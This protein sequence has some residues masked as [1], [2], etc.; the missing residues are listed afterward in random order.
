MIKKGLKRPTAMF[1][2]TSF[3]SPD[4]KDRKRQRGPRGK[5]KKYSTQCNTTDTTRLSWVF[6]VAR[7]GRPFQAIAIRAKPWT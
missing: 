2:V 3:I 7:L 4:V 6:E 1:Y 5:I